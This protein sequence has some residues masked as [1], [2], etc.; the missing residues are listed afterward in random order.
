MPKEYPTCAQCLA[1]KCL[2]PSRE[3]ETPANCPMTKYH[4]LIKKAAIRSWTDP[5]LKKLNMA[6]EKTLYNAYDTYTGIPIWHRLR[7]VIDFAKNLGFKKI[8]IAMCAG[9]IEEGRLLNNILVKNGFEVVSVNCMVHGQLRAE[10]EKE[11]GIN[12]AKEIGLKEWGPFFETL[13]F[14]GPVLQAEILNREKT[15]LNLMLGLCVGHDIIFIK[16]SKAYVSPLVVK[17]RVLGH[18]PVQALYASLADMRPPDRYTFSYYTQRQ[19]LAQTAEEEIKQIESE[20]M[21]NK[22]QLEKLERRLSEIKKT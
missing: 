5:E 12:I 2:Y 6:T 20:I 17:D 10:T 15:E 7:E 14:C 4:D 8:G 3:V 21:S 16:E 13:P 9:L 18:N 22:N 1:Y 19:I 11:I